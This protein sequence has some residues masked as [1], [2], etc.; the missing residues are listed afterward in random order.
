M[1]AIILA[2]AVLALLASLCFLTP[3]PSRFL[4]N[5]TVAIPELAP[6]V[7]VLD[8]VA[9]V[10]AAAFER[11]LLAPAAICFGI[12]AWPVVQARRLD[13]TL[14]LATLFRPIDQGGI[15]PVQ[16]SLNILYYAAAGDTPRP[17]IVAIYG[18]AWQRGEPSDD[19]AQNRY[20]AAHGYSV[21][22]ID[23]RHAPAAHFPSPLED[24]RAAIR[25]IA[26]HAAEYNVDP[27]KI[28]LCGHS[29]GG[30]LALLAAYQPGDTPI[31]GVV[32][33]YGPTNLKRGYD[34]LPATDPIDIREALTSY[35]GG[36]PAEK[37]TGFREASPVTWAG[38]RVPA[39]LLLQGLKDHVVKADFP[40]ELYERLV[41]SGND[42]ELVELPW[43][44]HAFDA[45][46]SGIGNRIALHRMME[47]LR[48]VTG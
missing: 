40:R 23:Y 43:A 29:S 31:R 5:F 3:A 17:A 44:E 33:F 16:L 27:A 35:I 34:E 19:A 41:A 45:V 21:F 7:A 25:F 46:F 42:A 36:T 22:A 18:G 15:R 9:I 1:R 13:P 26:E 6:W 39:T 4:L 37:P 2:L 14:T 20:L 10:L 8:L 30:Q 32:S 11:K 38:A 24:V 12:S 48:R 28:V 47:F